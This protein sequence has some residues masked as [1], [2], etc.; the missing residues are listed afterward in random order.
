MPLIGFSGAPFTLAAYAIEGGPSRQF[1]ATRQFMYTQTE[2]W[3][4]TD[5]VYTFNTSCYGCHVSQMSS[6]YDLAT[7]SYETTWTEF[8]TEV[9]YETPKRP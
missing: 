9:P 8:Q 5:A 7:D 2:A 1:A 6:N 4:W 3:H